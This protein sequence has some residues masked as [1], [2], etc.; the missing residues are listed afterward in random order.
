M[1]NQKIYNTEEINKIRFYALSVGNMQAVIEAD[2]HEEF[3]GKAVKV[4]KGRKNIGFTG[5][6]FYLAR[7]HYGSNPWTGYQTRIG[8]KN[9]SNEVIWTSIDNVKVC[10]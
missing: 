5:T 2:D 4:I 9:E 6:V 3:F 7:K 10:K 1:L 8:V